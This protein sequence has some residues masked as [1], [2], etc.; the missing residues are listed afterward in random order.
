MSKNRNIALILFGAVIL[1]YIGFA[2]HYPLVYPDTGTYLHSGFSGEV[3]NDRTIFYGLFAR[4]ISLASSPWL[5]IF[6]QGALLSY[7]LFRSFSLFFSGNKRNFLF[8]ITV[9][10]LTL[11]TGLSYNVSILLP[12]IFPAITV[13]CLIQLLLNTNLTR[14]ELVFV[15][16]LFV[17]SITVHLSNIPILFILLLILLWLRFKKYHKQNNSTLNGNRLLICVGLFIGS[18]I[19]IPSGHYLFGRKFQLSNGSHVFMLNH[20]REVGILRDYLDEACDEEEYQICDHLESLDG[21][22]MWDQNSALYKTGGWEANKDEYNRILG[23]IILTPKYFVLLAQKA[24]E[25]SFKQYFTFG[26]SVC[27]PQLGGSAPD[28]QIAWRFNDTLGEYHASLQN[29]A[30]L[31]F[32]ITNTIQEFVVLFSLVF[33]LFILLNKSRFRKLDPRIQWILVIV[34]TH[35]IIS[36]VLC[37]NLATVDPRFQ[38]RIIWMLPLLSFI[39]IVQHLEKDNLVKKWFTS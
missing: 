15:S 4:H 24:V 22:F 11:T 6:T 36:A 19:L 2:N 8:I 27:G 29:L 13:L 32:G 7:L 20:M 31:E 35:S 9:T 10:F 38:N 39:I 18:L 37:S 21:D 33:L 23:G 25:Y 17:F 14:F 26:I 30:K 5:I 12:D 16:V 28:G 1:C 3:P 34:F